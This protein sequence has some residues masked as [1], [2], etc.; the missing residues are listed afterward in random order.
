MQVKSLMLLKFLNILFCL[1]DFSFLNKFRLQIMLSKNLCN[2]VYKIESRKFYFFPSFFYN[3]KY[4][5]LFDKNF[6]LQLE[7]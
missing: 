4:F 7:K 6:Q 5:I 2:Q 1:I 3:Y